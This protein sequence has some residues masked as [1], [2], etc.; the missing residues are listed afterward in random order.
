MYL[1]FFTAVKDWPRPLPLAA[2]LCKHRS[3]LSSLRLPAVAVIPD[4]G[5]GQH[6]RRQHAISYLSYRPRPLYA[7]GQT[8]FNSER[9]WREES[10]YF[11]M[12]DRFHDDRPRTPTPEEGPLRRYPGPERV[13]RRDPEGDPREPRLYRRPRMHRH[14]ALPGLCHQC[15]PWL[16]HPKLP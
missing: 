7:P 4:R 13:L 1:S 8:Y 16:R 5:E 15:L 10:I 2:G 9:E 6:V 14:L 11:L 3:S 12:T